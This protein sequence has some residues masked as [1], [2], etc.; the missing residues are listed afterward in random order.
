M[1]RQDDLFTSDDMKVVNEFIEPIAQAAID[2]R[3]KAKADSAEGENEKVE[4]GEEVKVEEGASLLD[5]LAKLTSGK[6]TLGP[7]TTTTFHE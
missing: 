5:H 4:E 7:C 1:Q 6:L 2:R 3:Q